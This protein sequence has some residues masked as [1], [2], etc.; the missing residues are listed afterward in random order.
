MSRTVTVHGVTGTPAMLLSTITQSGWRV[1]GD[2]C[3]RKG[4]LLQ[5]GGVLV[6]RAR[7]DDWRQ[8]RGMVIATITC[9]SATANG[10][11]L[12]DHAIVPDQVSQLFLL[13]L[14]SGWVSC[15]ARLRLLLR[16]GWA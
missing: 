16:L 13:H 8:F 14:L 9:S 5:L 12:Q 10:V 11:V 3:L 2:Q 15:A 4:H 6:G 7:S 1:S